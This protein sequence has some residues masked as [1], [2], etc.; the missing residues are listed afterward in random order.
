MNHINAKRCRV[1]TNKTR[2]WNQTQ[3]TQRLNIAPSLPQNIGPNLFKFLPDRLKLEEN[4]AMSKILSKTL[5]RNSFLLYERLFCEW[6]FYNRTVLF[7]RYIFKKTL[8]L[9]Y[10][11]RQ[12]NLYLHFQGT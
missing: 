3:T 8:Y 11:N 7:L 4:I 10:L 6:L 2:Q 1:D 5:F 9:V 12:H